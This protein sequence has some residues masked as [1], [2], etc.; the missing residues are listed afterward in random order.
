E[1]PT[2]AAAGFDEVAFLAAFRDQADQVP[3]VPAITERTSETWRG[4]ETAA[5]RTE[6]PAPP[7]LRQI[8]V[9]RKPAAPWAH[10]SRPHTVRHLSNVF[11]IA[12][13]RGTRGDRP[14]KCGE[15][16]LEPES[17]GDRG[18]GVGSLT[19]QQDLRSDLLTVPRLGESLE[20]RCRLGRVERQPLHARAQ[21]LLDRIAGK[22][23]RTLGHERAALVPACLTLL[24]TQVERRGRF[25]VPREIARQHG[26]PER[27]R[28]TELGAPREQ[29]VPFG[30]ERGVIGHDRI[31]RTMRG[32]HDEGPARIGQELRL[33][34]AWVITMT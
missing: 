31:G 4:P 15:P 11:E 3:G 13:E 8:A 18:R 2:T 1:V 9:R 21:E 22:R 19:R 23:G 27:E 7:V 6:Q 12:F 24:E 32:P 14:Q 20:C 28:L 30:A 5:Q 26:G 25:S 34:Q 16:R 10:A 17:F 29:R 33:A